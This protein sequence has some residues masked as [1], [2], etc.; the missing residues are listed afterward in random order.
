MRNRTVAT[1]ASFAL[2]VSACYGIESE[3]PSNGGGNDSAHRD[4]GDADTPDGDS[5]DAGDEPDEVTIEVDFADGAQGWE[6]DYAEY[7]VGMEDGIDFVSEITER[8][9]DLDSEGDAFLLEASNSS[10]DLFMFLKHRLDDADGLEAN[11]EYEM[12]W[13]IEFASDAQSGCTGVGGAPGESVFM[14]AGGSP[15]EPDTYEEDDDIHVALDK[16]NQ[17]RDGAEASNAGD[18]ANGLE[19]DEE[20]EDYVR[21]VHEHTHDEPI[22]TDDQGNLWLVVGTDSGFEGRTDVYYL[23][24]EVTLR[25]AGG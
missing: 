22:S 2:L 3:L 6:G 19:C 10:D 1:I 9:D 7:S 25:P 24:L 15:S 4:N 8:P 17:S 11:T 13:R 21:L 12:D 5:D 23:S 18:I 20:P 14:K 16:G